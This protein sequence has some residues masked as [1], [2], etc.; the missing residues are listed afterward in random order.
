MAL[1]SV[2]TVVRWSHKKGLGGIKSP[3]TP[4]GC[5]VHFSCVLAEG[6]RVR[7]LEVGQ[8]VPFGYEAADQDGYPFRATWVGSFAPGQPRR[9]DPDAAAGASG[10]SP[11]YSSTLTITYDEP[12]D[13][14][15]T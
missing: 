13:A 9:P 12:D 10:P 15:G 5:W 2:G 1:E 6:N 3:D 11:A 14:P 8:V 7:E 4:G